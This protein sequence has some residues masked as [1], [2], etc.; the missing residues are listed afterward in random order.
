MFVLGLLV[1][2]AAAVGSVEL[3]IANRQPVTFHMWNWTWH[4]D[5]FWIAVIGAV[6]VTL[7]WLAL[8]AMRIAVVHQAR[9]RRERREL[10]AENERLAARVK[11]T[12][13]KA[14]TTAVGTNAVG[15][16]RPAQTPQYQ[17]PP[18]VGAPTAQ[19]PGGAPVAAPTTAA[20]T[21]SEA[22]R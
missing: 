5:A 20:A 19:A 4:V 21:P 12:D 1:L 13:T 9:L 3:I 8:G 15:T 10:A 6:A 11:R 16:N 2:A 7:V 18:T 17:P 22:R 14:G